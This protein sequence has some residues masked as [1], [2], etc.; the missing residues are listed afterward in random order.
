MGKGSNTQG[1]GGMEG[2]RKPCCLANF[3]IFTAECQNI[4]FDVDKSR[5]VFN[6]LLNIFE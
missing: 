2:K 6:I 5:R 1:Q 4:L 3:L